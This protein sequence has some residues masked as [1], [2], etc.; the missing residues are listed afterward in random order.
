MPALRILWKSFPVALIA[1]LV[2][3]SVA[4]Q[5][6]PTPERLTRDQRRAVAA[7]A[8]EGIFEGTS[9]S[10]SDCGG[11]VER[12]EVALWIVRLLDGEAT[13]HRTFVDVGSEEPYAGYVQTLFDLGVTVGCTVDPLRYCPTSL[14]RRG[15]MAAFVT[16]AYDLDDTIPPNR[17][18]DVPRTNTFRDNISALNNAFIE[19]IN[20]GDRLFCPDD[21]IVAAEA[22]DWLYQ[23]S[24]LESTNGRNG[25]GSGGG[26]SGGGGSGGGGSGGG[27]GRGGGSGGG[28][29][30]GGGSGGG[31][32]GGGGGNGGGGTTPT[33]IT[34]SGPGGAEID[35]GPDGECTHFDPH[36]R[37]R[38]VGNDLQRVGDNKSHVLLAED[39]R[40]DGRTLKAGLYAHRHDGST[41]RWWYWSHPDP[42]TDEIKGP[43]GLP[44]SEL[45]IPC[46]HVCPADHMHDSNGEFE[47]SPG[48]HYFG[49]DS[50]RVRTYVYKSD[51]TW[52]LKGLD[53]EVIDGRDGPCD[54]TA[55][56]SH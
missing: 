47:Y 52:R 16:R 55:A 5:E 49:D 23:A 30:G 50:E 13:S 12:W 8:D 2:A 51:G 33:A 15:Q 54:H 22:V 37:F 46:E 29:S 28:G 9:C 45:P 3:G 7:F 31:G 34:S 24:R 21:P 39:W 42:Q 4:A 18:A 1:L 48:A 6:T 32:S 19:T 25:G 36:V 35:I 56:H 10:V 38:Q 40:S 43:I 26:G 17:F 41:T 20:C 53:A 27:G 14:T 11:T 44:T